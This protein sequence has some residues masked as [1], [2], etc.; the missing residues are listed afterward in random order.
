[1]KDVIFEVCVFN[2]LTGA[3][4]Y[5]EVTEEVFHAF[6]RSGWH[7]DYTNR[8]FQQFES[9][10]S[11]L[12]GPGGSSFE[13]S[14][15]LAFDVDF[16][17]IVMTEQAKAALAKAIRQLSKDELCLIKAVFIDGKS[18]RGYAKEIGMPMMTVQNRKKQLLKKIRYVMKE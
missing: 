3:Y 5:V 6:Q 2:T 8:R 9:R 13:D 10:F 17:Q 15:A 16:A 1:M 12:R 4:E 7:I 18:V 11:E 14:S